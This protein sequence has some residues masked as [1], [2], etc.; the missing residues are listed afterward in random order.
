[1]GP[2]ARTW[3]IYLNDFFSCLLML[4]STNIYSNVKLHMKNT[5]HGL[6]DEYSDDKIVIQK[7]LIVNVSSGALVKFLAVCDVCTTM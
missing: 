7:S 5:K 1:M 6:Y 3:F 2:S 4:L